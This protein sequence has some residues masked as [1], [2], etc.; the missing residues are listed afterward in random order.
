MVVRTFEEAVERHGKPEAVMSDRGSA[1]WAWRGIS[2]F[3]SL[4]TE[5]GVDQLVAQHKEHNGKVEVFNANLHK[6]LFD[7]YR[8]YDLAEMK[9]RLVGHL[10]WYNHGR[11]HHALGGL[12][13]PADRYYGRADEVLAR[14]EAGV[15]ARD[16]Q[17]AEL[18]ERCLE[19][20]RVVSKGG[21]PEVWLLGQRLNVP[22]GT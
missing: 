6:E 15:P 22:L 10:D 18:R 14:I 19:L 2:R 11:T 12:L 7:A 21:V 20:F 8:F 1:F 13:V 9:R 4:L 17:E 3:T 16:G 5:M